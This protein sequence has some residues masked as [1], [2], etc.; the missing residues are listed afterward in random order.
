MTTAKPVKRPRG[1]GPWAL[2]YREPLNPN[3]QF[4]KDDDA[5]NV[6]ARTV[7][8]PVP[9]TTSSLLAPAA[10]GARDEQ[11]D[12]RPYAGAIDPGKSFVALEGLVTL[13]WCDR[14]PSNGLVAVISKN[15]DRLAFVHHRLEPPGADVLRRAL[16]LGAA[17]APTHAGTVGKLS[18]TSRK[19]RQVRRCRAGDRA[20]VDLRT[21][22]VGAHEHARVR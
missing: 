21:R 4:K 1:E 5:L 22:S 19:R 12:D 8:A 7:R 18:M 15:T 9:T 10:A 16:I 14:T 6:R 3:E 17:H 11:T 2:G 20:I 13:A